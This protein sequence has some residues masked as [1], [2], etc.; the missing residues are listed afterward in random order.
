MATRTYCSQVNPA[1]PLA[2]TADP[3]G[4]WVLV[5]YRPTWKP[6]AQADNTLPPRV[7]DWLMR[8]LTAL[9]ESGIR[10]RPQFI[11]RAVH[12]APGVRLVVA[13]PERT[14]MFQAD[15][16]DAFVA[17]D[18]ACL[19]RQPTAATIPA[20]FAQGDVTAPLYFVCTNGQ[21]DVCCAR[22]GLPLY[23]ALAETVGARAWQITH[24]GGHRFA[25]NVL[26]LPQGAV[27]GRVTPAAATAFVAEIEAGRLAFAQLRGRSF[28]PPHVQAA[29]A[30]SGRDGLRLLGVAG[31]QAEA[32]VRF[33]LAADILEIGVRRAAGALQV[34]ASC[35]A[36]AAEPI[37][38]F[39]RF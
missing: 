9:A 28:Y 13:G 18:L 34:L 3:V 31:D 30:F 20:G 33:A 24:L 39:E 27:Y 17:L 12:D 36:E 19:V 2:G 16:H 1:E 14:V 22:Y 32:R 29:E 6:R 15:D 8:Q 38:P 5:E 7:R 21:R 25:P 10:A 26:V 4:A 11:R 23:R 35:G 37:H